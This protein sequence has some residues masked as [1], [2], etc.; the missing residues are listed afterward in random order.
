MAFPPE[1]G[2][3]CNNISHYREKYLLSK[4]RY[5]MHSSKSIYIIYYILQL[6]VDVPHVLY[7]INTV[8]HSDHGTLIPSVAQSQHDVHNIYM[9]RPGVIHVWC[10]RA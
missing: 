6:H 3:S 1:G 10:E 4:L 8:Y 7:I 9:Y 2:D 5:S